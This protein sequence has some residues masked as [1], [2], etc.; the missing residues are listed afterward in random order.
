[1]GCDIH[2]ITQYK[3]KSK[4]HSYWI[5]L[6]NS[7]TINPGRN[8][9]LFGL[10]CKGVRSDDERGIPS[11]GIPEDGFDSWS[12]KNNF[13]YWV[14]DNE[15]DEGQTCSIERANDWIRKEYSFWIEENKIVSGPDWHHPSWLTGKEF[16]KC[17]ELCES[18]NTDW[19]AR[20]HVLVAGLCELERRGF[21]TRLIFWFD[22]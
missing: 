18:I 22:N 7:D 14:T 21:E 13:G 20:W 15:T 16:R 19:E 3:S 11:R 9:E 4:E 10:M 1:M 12:V 5:D 6:Y 8:Y 17:V 2:L